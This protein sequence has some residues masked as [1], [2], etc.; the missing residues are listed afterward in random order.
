VSGT[1][2]RRK[3]ALEPRWDK[4]FQAQGFEMTSPR[5]GTE[6]RSQTARIV[7]ASAPV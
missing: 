5:K 6:T 4:G 3:P 7:R 1:T 2:V